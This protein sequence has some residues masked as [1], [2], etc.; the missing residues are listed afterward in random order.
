MDPTRREEPDRALPVV[1]FREALRFWIR[2]GFINFG[3]PSGQI[4]IMHEE[5]VERRR[6]ISNAH[7]TGSMGKGSAECESNENCK[8]ATRLGRASGSD[9]ENSVNKYPRRSWLGFQ[10]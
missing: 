9:K 4:A 8:R 5:L 3:G 2:L 1:P 6:W 10:R 7:S